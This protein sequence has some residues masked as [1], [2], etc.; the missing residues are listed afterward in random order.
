M[1]E[2]K[3]MF[4]VTRTRLNK[5]SLY[6][7]K[8]MPASHWHLWVCSERAMD[9]YRDCRHGTRGLTLLFRSHIIIKSPYLKLRL[10]HNLFSSPGIL[11]KPA[12]GREFVVC[13]FFPFSQLTYLCYLCFL[14]G[15]SQSRERDGG[16]GENDIV[17]WLAMVKAG[18]PKWGLQ[19]VTVDPFLVVEF[20][21]FFRGFLLSSLLFRLP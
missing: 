5:P 2:Q 1:K 9:F 15:R 13:L 11:H 12:V 4:F 3:K 10:K 19:V 17:T 6:W 7:S 8:S 16:R 20:F 18:I 21:G 14:S